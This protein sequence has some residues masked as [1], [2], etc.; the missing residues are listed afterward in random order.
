MSE[1][2]VQDFVNYL[3]MLRT[4]A[5]VVL[6]QG[7]EKE[8]QMTSK[9]AHIIESIAEEEGSTLEEAEQVLFDSLKSMSKDRMANIVQST[10]V[11]KKGE[12]NLTAAEK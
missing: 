6:L 2:Q 8:N 10:F 9:L 7:T 3:D 4:Q 5:R 11:E 1:D 12:L